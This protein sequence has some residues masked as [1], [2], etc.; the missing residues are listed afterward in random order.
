MKRYTNLII[1]AAALV[2]AACVF[3]IKNVN[4][5]DL[6]MT[7]GVYDGK[8]SIANTADV[9]GHLV[10]DDEVGGYYSME[11][12]SVIMGLPLIK[13]F[14]D[15]LRNRNKDT[16]FLDSGDFFHGTNEANLN[17][18][19]GLVKA[20]NLMGYN[21]MVPGNHDFNFGFDRLLKIKSELDF[22][23][24]SANIYKDGE[25]AFE[26]Y[27]VL[28]VGGVKIGLFG[29]TTPW[30]LSFNNS[31]DNDG[32]TIEDPVKSALRVVPI[33]K[34]KADIVVLISHLGDD[35]DEEVVKK[36]DG[37]D[38]VLAG[39]YHN[40]YKSA[41]KIGDTYIV[42]AGGWTT[43][44]G[45]AD[46]YLKNNKVAGVSWKV[47]TSKDK[48][49]TDKE[50]NKIAQEYH[51]L[52]LESAKEVLGKTEVKL[53][54]IR[55]QLRSKETNLG[56]LLA[57]AMRAY[58]NADIALM[59]G[60]GIRESIP[61]GEINLYKIGKVLPFSNSLVIVEMK[62][63]KIYRAI[64]RGIRD[65]TSGVNGGFLQVSGIKY[66]FD[67]SKPAGERL[68]SVE[69]DGQPLDRN[70]YYLVATNDYLYNG[71]DNYE[72]F[73]NIRLVSMGSLLK[74]VLAQYIKSQGT[75]SPCE[76]GRIKVINE[77]YK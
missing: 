16:L 58:G 31:R 61:Q 8:V 76:E 21:A 47:I 14:V 11:D 29:L 3:I 20:A 55:S 18:G 35:V 19:E 12:V 2:T 15:D 13:H 28:D 67:G 44:L 38:L 51:T 64:E 9:H 62:G 54:G 23:I 5:G 25:L 10:F 71:G 37:I 34:D 48:S 45:I 57:D 63:D 27:S 73:K 24:L 4:Y 77:R 33:L 75:V 53:N 49:L 41:K 70:K 17:K 65:Y 74:D 7:A 52:A 60:G 50:L 56:N 32:V 68:I 26:E 43:H 72:E 42:E 66:V 40:L 30:A 39:H 46:I 22:P 1:L 6:L 36:V 69:K 59:N